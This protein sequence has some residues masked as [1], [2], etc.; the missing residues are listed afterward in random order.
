[1]P[2]IHWG[3]FGTGRMAAQMA[4]ELLRHEPQ[5]ARLIAV[6]SRDRLRATR[7]AERFNIE[8][9]HASYAELA[10]DR[11]VD[12]V[13]IAT[14]PSEHHAQISLCLNNGKAVLCEKPFTTDATQARDV[15][16]LARANGLFLMEAMWT[17]FLPAS[18]ALRRLVSEGAIGRPQLLVGGGAFIPT[19]DPD[20]YLLSARLGG[21]VLLDAGVYLISLAS[22]LLGE[23]RRVHASGELGEHGVDEHD[24]FILEHHGGARAL[25]YV[26]LR[27]RRPPDLEVLG[28]A[29]RIHILAPVFR[30][31]RLTLS[32][33]ARD[34]ETLEF[35][36]EGSGYSYQLIAAMDALRTGRIETP[37]MP[38]DETQ[39]IMSTMD[40]IRRQFLAL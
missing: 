30:P 40:E 17:R 8:A 5:G 7:F 39:A 31:T 16:Q 24:C 6:A 12:V 32:R 22:M 15:I 25:L 28:D 21:G 38:L 23:V 29:G 1:M 26:S 27:A 2:P 20:H 37:E 18:T 36:I 14:P 3:I 33:P 11:S 34:D 10:Q 9:A 13:Y 35:P 4:Q 19:P